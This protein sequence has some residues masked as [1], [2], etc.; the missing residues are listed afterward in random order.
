[1]DDGA[2]DIRKFIGFERLL[3]EDQPSIELPDA[4]FEEETSPSLDVVK[5]EA[6]L[7]LV[8][9]LKNLI[10]RWRMLREGEGTELNRGVEEGFM[11]AAE[12]LEAK[13]LKYESRIELGPDF[14]L[15]ED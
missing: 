12:D 15:G 4:V 3:L 7:E 10:Q 1:M 2:I 5:E 13:L 8:E 11:R 9:D 6:Q 14:D